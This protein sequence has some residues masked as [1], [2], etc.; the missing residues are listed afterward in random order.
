MISFIKSYKLYS[1]FQWGRKEE[2]LLVDKWIDFNQM[3]SVRWLK[4]TLWFTLTVASVKKV[5]RQEA[6]ECHKEMQKY[7]ARFSVFSCCPELWE[8]GGGGAFCSLSITGWPLALRGEDEEY[9]KQHDNG[10][11][12]ATPTWSTFGTSHCHS[13]QV[14]VARHSFPAWI[15]N[16]T[17]GTVGRVTCFLPLPHTDAH[18]AVCSDV[19]LHVHAVGNVL[20]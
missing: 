2:K 4:G 8:T 7:D 17:E 3:L 10:K 5:G 1:L 9:V 14:W 15:D 12:R 6:N 20:E 18:A 13:L 11:K 16:C 19:A